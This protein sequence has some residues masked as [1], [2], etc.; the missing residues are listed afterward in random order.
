LRESRERDECEKRPLEIEVIHGGA[1]VAGSLS[2]VACPFDVSFSSCLVHSMS[3]GSLGM[4]T[5][6]VII[7]VSS[8]VSRADR[9]PYPG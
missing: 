7:F 2:R 8:V 3:L 1:F 4:V 9:A 5:L 6:V